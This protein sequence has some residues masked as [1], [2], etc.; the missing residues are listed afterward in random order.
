M[1]HVSTF[2]QYVTHILGIFVLFMSSAE[3]VFKLTFS[4]KNS[5]R[6]RI[7]VSNGLDPDQDRRYVGPDL[8][9]NCFKGYQ[10]TPLV[11]N[12]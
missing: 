2:I 8:G 3:L 7:R 12:Q 10:Q 11:L 1:D 5:F 6:N 4:K 9:P